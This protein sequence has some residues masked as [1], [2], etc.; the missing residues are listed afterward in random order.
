[1]KQQDDSETVSGNPLLLTQAIP[2][3]GLKPRKERSSK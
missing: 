2:E 1:M 3:T